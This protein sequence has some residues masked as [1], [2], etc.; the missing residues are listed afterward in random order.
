MESKFDRLQ[1]F[2]LNALDRMGERYEILEMGCHPDNFYLKVDIDGL[3]VE[4]LEIDEEDELGHVSLTDEDLERVNSD[5]LKISE[6]ARN[7]AVSISQ[8]V[9]RNSVRY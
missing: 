9:N 8:R 5:P 2:F 6:D 7:L 3:K 1:R 4:L